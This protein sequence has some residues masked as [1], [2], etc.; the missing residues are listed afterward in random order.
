[1][2]GNGKFQTSGILELENA[3]VHVIYDLSLS[4]QERK[5]KAQLFR[6]ASYLARHFGC[7]PCRII[8]HREPGKRFKDKAGKEWAIRIASA[9]MIK[10]L[11][12]L[13]KL[14]K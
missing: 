2:S 13:G 7:K 1:M 10:K 4:L 5:E 8:S 12:K 6:N 14:G 9:E 11:G 3:Q